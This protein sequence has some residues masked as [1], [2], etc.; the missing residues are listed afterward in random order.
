MATTQKFSF[1][2]VTGG[3]SIPAFGY[4]RNVRLDKAPLDL[5][6]PPPTR[7]RLQN[8]KTRGDFHALCKPRFSPTWLAIPRD[9][10]CW[11]QPHSIYPCQSASSSPLQAN[12]LHA[13][14]LRFSRM[15]VAVSC[16]IAQGEFGFAQDLR[17]SAPKNT[18]WEDD[19]LISSFF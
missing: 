19:G 10:F 11:R 9:F 13:T 17:K 14:Y 6:L 8:Q 16:S 5:F 7:L 18:P 15:C 4:E 3:K 2:A 12:C 1:L